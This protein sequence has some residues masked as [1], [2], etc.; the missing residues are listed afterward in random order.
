MSEFTITRTNIAMPS[1][2]EPV[3]SLLFGA[4]D[5]FSRD[6]K[7]SWRKFWKR[8]FEAEPGELVTV[9]MRF[10]RCGIFHRRHML[11]EQRV[12][13]AQERFQSFEQFRQW[14]KVG[15][16]WVDW[17]AGPKGGVVPIPRS[18]SY[19]SADQ[20]EFERFHNAVV[21]FLRGPHAARFLW[22]HLG[23][24]AHEAMDAAL[25]EFKGFAA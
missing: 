17:C 11:L 15:A 24:K 3:R 1:Q 7:R 23:D 18:I 10:P 20:D 6:D 4:L 2:L 13:D 21:E 22:R 19:A 8:L 16:G 5:G 12:F 9:E 25:E 14:L